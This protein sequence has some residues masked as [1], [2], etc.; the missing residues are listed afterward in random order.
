[1]LGIQKFAAKRAAMCG[2]LRRFIAN[3]DDG[4]RGVAAIEFA[5]IAASLILMMICV[6]DIGIGL[7]RKMQVQNAA[8]AGA[9]YA[10]VHGF[11]AS[12][13]ASAV[14]A[15][16][17]FSGITASPAPNQYCGCPSNTGIAS[18]DCSSTC[19]DGSK[20]G[21]YVAVSAQG[22]YDTILQYPLISNSFTLTAQSTVRIP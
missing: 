9:Q 5:M 13:I 7:Y 15:A 3:G 1:M 21:T 22:T 2:S 12:S 4:I 17:T 6:V 10:I 14:T 11:A 20:P 19:S 8:Q 18:T 16:T